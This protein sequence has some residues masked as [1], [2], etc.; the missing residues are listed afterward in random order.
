[1]PMEAQFPTVV[2]VPVHGFV[3]RWVLISKC[4]QLEMRSIGLLKSLLFRGKD[5]PIK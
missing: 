4:M 1:M 5:W 3:W 2:G